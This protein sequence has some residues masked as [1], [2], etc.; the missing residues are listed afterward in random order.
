MVL[1]LGACSPEREENVPQE[2]AELATDALRA[3]SE[4]KVSGDIDAVLRAHP[5][6]PRYSAAMRKHFE[7]MSRLHRVGLQ[8]RI[9]YRRYSLEVRH[10]QFCE[11]ERTAKLAVTTLVRYDMEAVPPNAGSPGST[12]GQEEHGF[13]FERRDG[14]AWVMVTHHEI[15]LE[16][17]HRKEVVTRLRNPCG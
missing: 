5:L 1:L 11:D 13:G 14:S 8:T 3:A 9:R 10:D 17:M 4:V 7:L 2:I 16:E 15:S 6:S 12:S